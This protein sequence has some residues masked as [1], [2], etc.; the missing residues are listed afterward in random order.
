MPRPARVELP[1]P[2]FT[3]R[4]AECGNTSLKAVLAFHGLRF[5]ARALGQLAGT[6]DE[7]IKSIL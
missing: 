4:D 3:Q 7:G 5:S 1:V 6:N 2:I